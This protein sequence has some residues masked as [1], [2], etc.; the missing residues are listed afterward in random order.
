MLSSSFIHV[1]ADC[2]IFFFH[3]IVWYSMTHIYVYTY[4]LQLFVLF[5][6][7]YLCSLDYLSYCYCTKVLWWTYTCIYK[8]ELVFLYCNYRCKKVAFLD[9]KRILFLFF[10]FFFWIDLYMCSIKAEPDEIPNNSGSRILP[11]ESCQYWLFPDFWY[12]PLMVIRE[13]LIVIL[14][15]ISLILNDEHIFRSLLA[16]CMFSLEKCLFI[17]LSHL[18]M[19]SLDFFVVGFVSAL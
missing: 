8:L 19:Q 10:F 17:F 9:H 18:G 12:V 5:I 6:H 1:A 13:Y 4:I 2:M 11:L 16:I 14:I 3:R 15:C 7:P